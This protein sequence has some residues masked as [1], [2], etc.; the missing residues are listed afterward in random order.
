MANPPMQV[1]P[2][3]TDQAQSHPK[4]A[5]GPQL[6]EATTPP[7]HRSNR[8]PARGRP[9]VQPSPLAATASHRD[10]N[11]QAKIRKRLA[12]PDRKAKRSTVHDPMPTPPPSGQ[13]TSGGFG[14]AKPE[15][16]ESQ[17]KT[18]EAPRICHSINGIGETAL[19]QHWNQSC[20]GSP[21]PTAS[22]IERRPC[23][24]NCP[25]KPSKIRGTKSGP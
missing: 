21:E 3:R 8:G 11:L 2:A 18:A 7:G 25:C 20:Q 5:S 19:A 1:W 12:T 23:R 13:P 9:K 15:V 4:H 10:N 17:P 6:E 16:V 14:F 22:P 24:S